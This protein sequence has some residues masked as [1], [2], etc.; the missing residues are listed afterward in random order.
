MLLNNKAK[1]N[2][3]NVKLHQLSS[4]VIIFQEENILPL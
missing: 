1:A 2:L 3:K 4:Q